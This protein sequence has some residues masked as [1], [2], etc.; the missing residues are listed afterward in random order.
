MTGIFNKLWSSIKK[1]RNNTDIE[2][3][4]PVDEIGQKEK[5]INRNTHH[6]SPRLAALFA[7]AFA[8]P[9]ID[10]PTFLKEHQSFLNSELRR[11][12]YRSRTFVYDKL[13][14]RVVNQWWILRQ[15]IRDINP[16]ANR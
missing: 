7:E 10:D 2:T 1:N 12:R 13:F 14:R 9:D 16:T 4:Q 8:P 15:N 11:M 6:N 3:S 5:S